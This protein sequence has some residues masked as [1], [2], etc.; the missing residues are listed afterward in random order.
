MKMSRSIA[1]VLAWTAV[2][3]AGACSSST[4][5]PEGVADGH[6]PD[7]PAVGL[8]ASP[9]HQLPDLFAGEKRPRPDLYA[10]KAPGPTDLT[11]FVNLGDSIAAGYGVAATLNYEVLL[12]TNDNDTYPDW[13]GKDFDTKFP[14]IQVSDHAF[15]GAT[16]DHLEAQVGQVPINQGGSTLVVISI[17]G[18]DL[19]NSY[20]ALLDPAQTKALANTV[21]K[22]VTK[23]V[24]HFKDTTKY[25]HPTYFVIF[26]IYDPTDGMAD[27][28]AD[29]DVISM[30]KS[31]KALAPLFGKQVM[32]NFAIY[33]GALITMA[34][35]QQ[36]LVGDNH[37]RFLGHA[38][39]YSDKTSLF[40]DVAD[41]T[42]WLQK[43]CIHPNERGH[44]E[45]RREVWRVL[46]G[47]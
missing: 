18:N 11:M 30:C 21:E 2:I 33:N 17:G 26:T 3:G 46:F 14:G 47:E 29:A 12:T 4:A 24:D 38:F 10:E 27:I 8:E 28:P 22:N 32:A 1:L 5:S 16:S 45:L 41:P 39:Y 37:A 42:L 9:D 44:H 15:V 36:M 19:M 35:K 40:Y 20:Q 7:H 13:K 34:G 43:D 25:P 23:V 31:F 6:R